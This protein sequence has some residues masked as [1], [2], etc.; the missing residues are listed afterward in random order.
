MSQHHVKKEA[1]F[2]WS[3]QYNNTFKLLKSELV[4]MPAL[5]YPNPNKLFKLFTCAS[6][7]SYSGNLHQEQTSNEPN[8]E[9]NL[10]PIAYFSGSFSR[11][12]QLYS[13][14]PHRRSIMSSTNQPKSLHCILQEQNVCYTVTMSH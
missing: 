13:R 9:S 8:V 10:T 3:E 2:N 1:M 11:T 5:Q 12:Q 6:K 14:T 7:H 4:K